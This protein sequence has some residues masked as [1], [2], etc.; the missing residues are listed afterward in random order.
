MPDIAR[1][2]LFLNVFIRGQRTP[3]RRTT[4]RRHGA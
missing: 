3:T 4:R 2:E 1:F